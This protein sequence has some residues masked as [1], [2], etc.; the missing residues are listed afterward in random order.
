MAKKLS[1]LELDLKA[2]TGPFQKGMRRA[3]RS[4]KS[5][6]SKIKAG[7]P[8]LAK[9][10]KKGLLAISAAS[11]AAAAGIAILLKKSF[12]VVDAMAKMSG[13]MGIAI[14]K[15][16]GF[17]HIAELTGVANE[18]LQKGLLLMERGISEAARG[19]GEAKRELKLL[20]LNAGKLIKLKVED[21]FIAISKAMLTIKSPADRV[22]IAMKLF[23]RSGAAL[24]NALQLGPEKLKALLRE[25]EKLFGNLSR[26]DAAKIENANDAFSRVKAT[27]AGVSN[28]VAVKLAPIVEFVSNKFVAWAGQGEKLRGKLKSVFDSAVNGVANFLNKAEPVGRFLGELFSV[29]AGVVKTQ[30]NVIA[31]ALEFL[32][33][34]LSDGILGNSD[35]DLNSLGLFDRMTLSVKKM[36]ITF[37]DSFAGILEIFQTFIVGTKKMVNAV[38]EAFNRIPKIEPTKILGKT[39]LPGLNLPQIEKIDEGA[40]AGL[41]KSIKFLDTARNKEREGLNKFR[42]DVTKPNRKG[43][44]D[45]AKDGVTGFLSKVNASADK[46]AA[47]ALKSPVRAFTDIEDGADKTTESVDKLADSFENL[48]DKQ[49]GSAQTGKFS[50]FVIGGGEKSGPGARGGRAA[51]ASQGSTG[52]GHAGGGQSGGGATNESV[53]RSQVLDSLIGI[54][55]N[56]RNAGAL[57]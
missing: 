8:T 45:R 56:T 39:V 38:I 16:A 40:P 4:V 3:G 53:W 29:T 1:V 13:S 24:V 7:V 12:S 46:T 33:T 49:K 28:V 23:G 2:K 27:I 14:G 54:R 25:G 22:A 5:F 32:A 6:T 18:G 9:F 37:L 55:N 50:R 19:I 11:V 43:L 20:G 15:L 44:G 47:D 57:G 52:G 21:Q 34:K 35:K 36:K 10:A 31:G 48:E 51:K 41:E 30:V 26:I 17:R 42:G